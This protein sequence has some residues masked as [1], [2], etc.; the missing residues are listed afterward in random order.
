MR[1][2]AVF[3]SM[4][5]ILLTGTIV[6]LIFMG[7]PNVVIPVALT[8]TEL[9]IFMILFPYVVTRLHLPETLSKT[10]KWFPRHLSFGFRSFMSGA[11]NEINTRVDV[12]MLG[13]FASDSQVGIY[14]FASTLASGFLQLPMVLRWNLDPLL[15]AHFAKKEISSINDL[16]KKVRKYF[17]P[18]L[19]AIC[20]LV[21]LTYPFIFSLLLKK[22][23][24]ATASWEVFAILITGV[25]ITSR[26]RPFY[27][28]LLQGG[29]PGTHSLMIA[30]LTIICV[31][32]NLALVPIFG[33][34]GA[35]FSMT[36]M[37]SF[38]ATFLYFNT[39]R[40]FGIKL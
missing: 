16:V 17:Y 37:Y 22:S 27:G 12:L 6:G 31:V 40:L 24:I 13:L 7:V 34:F 19:V 35:A 10:F 4:R 26:F 36:L 28:I 9:I 39:K 20:C 18:V 3:Q 14:S 29:Y 30:S 25:L 2:Y 23:N 5:Y 1:T 38:E 11:L 33:I 32:L 15:G 21:V 8:L